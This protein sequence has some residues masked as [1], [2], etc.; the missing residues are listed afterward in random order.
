[1]RGGALF[2]LGLLAG[3][4]S[5]SPSSGDGA[6][7]ASDAPVCARAD[8]S[9]PKAVPS[10]ANDIAP[11]VL[12]ACVPCH[13]PMSNLAHSSLATYPSVHLVY[14]SALGQVEACLMP[15][16]GVPPLTDAER[17]ALLGWL[18]CGAPDN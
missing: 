14:G 8:P 13:Y 5:G 17:T 3:C 12:D 4:S 16:P 2:A 9:C 7:A 11:I 15:P 1:M 6:D 18:A 10:Y